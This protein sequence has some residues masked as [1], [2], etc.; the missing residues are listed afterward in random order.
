MPVYYH[1]LSSKWAIEDLKKQRIKVGII[2]EL[3]DPFELLPY[4]RYKDKEKIKKY[5]KCRKK[6]SK[7]Y[8]FL[9]FSQTWEEPLLWSHYADKHKGIAIGFEI[10]KERIFRVGYNNDL[11]IKFELTNNDEKNQNLFLELAKINMQN[12]H[13]KKNIA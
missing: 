11:R 1:F 7:K 5:Y 2:K 13:M 4:L 8:G 10:L 3:N 9:F 12:G 6:I